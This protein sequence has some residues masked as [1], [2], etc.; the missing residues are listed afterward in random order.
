MSTQ[1]LPKLG[2]STFNNK[3]KLTSCVVFVTGNK[4]KLCEVRAILKDVIDVESHNLDC[5]FKHIQ[6]YTIFNLIMYKVPELQG[7]TQEIAKQ[8]CKLA[9]ETVIHKKMSKT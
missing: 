6:M 2:M 4:N 7:E 5:K 8:K 3:Y 1:E 9:A